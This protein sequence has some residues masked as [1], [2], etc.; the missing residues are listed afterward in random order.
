VRDTLLLA[1]YRGE[2]V[3]ATVAGEGKTVKPITDVAV[4]MLHKVGMTV[5]YQVMDF[6]A[7]VQRRASKKPPAEGGWSIVAG[8]FAAIDCLTPAT[9][10][11]LRGNGERAA[12]GWPT[13]LAIE[14]LRE[15]WFDALDLAAQKAICAEIQVQA[16]LDLPYFPL[17]QFYP[18]VAFRAD[19]TGIWGGQPL[20]W[21]VRR[22]G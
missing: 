14:A 21:N 18:T 19:L 6:S 8:G 4:D 3:V 15:R 5:D 20:F 9:H 11:P 7:F 12:Y 16:F 22:Q 17:G 10:I 2:T 1:G 13:S